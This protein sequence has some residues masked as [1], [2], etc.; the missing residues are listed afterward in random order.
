VDA[1]SSADELRLLAEIQDEVG[2]DSSDDLQRLVERGTELIRRLVGAAAATIEIGVAHGETLRASAG[3]APP[4]SLE[5]GCPSLS[6]P[7]GAPRGRTGVITVVSA[8]PAGLRPSQALLVRIAGGLL[9]AR[10]E[11]LER[12]RESEALIAEN[13]MALGT[14]RDSELRFRNAFDH[15]GIG[16]ALV[17]R[18][19]RWLK[20]NAAL[21]RTLGYSIAELLAQSTLSVTH[22]DD[23]H[24]EAAAMARLLGGAIPSD[25]IEKRYIHASGRV[26]WGL[27]TLSAVTDAR[28]QMLY[29]ICQVQDITARKEAEEILRR[30]ALR[31]SLTGLFNRGEL[32][33]LLGEEISRARRHGRALS[34]VMVDVDRFKRVN[35]TFGH[36]AGDRV[37]QQV[38]NV[39]A[40]CLR[41]HDR[42][43]RY[44][45]EEFAVILP[46]TTGSDALAVAERMRARV[47]SEVVIHARSEDANVDWPITI[48]VGIASLRDED[49]EPDALARDLM[50]AADA[51]LYAA[52]RGGR[53]RCVVTSIAGAAAH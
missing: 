27:A 2:D 1:A 5:G 17:G 3:L 13:T 44:G 48:S 21:G 53:N 16:M 33:R 19:G 8:H 46:E 22:P 29:F 23:V 7:I 31:D 10:I 12:L 37:L 6:L 28:G 45:G 9:A 41:T 30:H 51:G 18:D 32:D 35:D 14:L 39:L 20:V 43:A 38:A 11:H 49:D 42:V 40:G 47:A 52:K 25:E 50:R 24:L 26:V 34:L 15:S 36:P 4:P